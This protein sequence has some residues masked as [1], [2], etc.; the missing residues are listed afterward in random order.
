MLHMKL[1]YILCLYFLLGLC[2]SCQ[3]NKQTSGIRPDLTIGFFPSSDILPY[4]V[5]QQNGYYDS[6]QVRVELRCLQ[7]KTELDTTYKK[8]EIDGAV[9]SLMDALFLSAQGN[10]IHPVMA[11]ESCFYLIGSPDSSLLHINQLYEKSIAVSSYAESDY[12]ADYLIHAVGLT[13]DEVNKPSIGNPV[14]RLEM[15]INQQ[16]NGAILQDP[17]ATQAI[18]EGGLKLYAFQPLN[19][20]L[21]VTAFSRQA[22]NEKNEFIRKL[23]I[24]YNKAVDYINNQPT[25]LWYRKA[26]SAAGLGGSWE[27]PYKIATYHAARFVDQQTADS[28]VSWMKRY[29]LLPAR[30]VE[31]VIDR[32]LIKNINTDN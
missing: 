7:T 2:T 18:R 20:T 23:I 17:Y 25:D 24:G 21:S 3:R 27:P 8:G 22:L 19:Q 6:L 13:T 32:T 5:A 15:L 31:D 29:E 4:F 11:N 1:S 10:K 9:L 12:L 16:V 30:Y 26:A 14:T 28:V